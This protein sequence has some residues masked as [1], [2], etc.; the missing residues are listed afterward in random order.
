[1]IALQ[2]RIGWRKTAPFHVQL[3]L[4]NSQ[5]VPSALGETRVEGRAIRVF[6]TDGRLAVGDR[7][8]FSI[9]VC[10]SGGE[11]TGPAYIYVDDLSRANLMEAYLHGTPPEYE[12]AAYEFRIIDTAS[13]QP[14]LTLLAEHNTPLAEEVRTPAKRRRWQ[15]WKPL[16]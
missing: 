3:E 1:M 4:V 6:R 2:G 13:E 7:I 12:L 5:C 8:A 10:E 16:K 9:W 14:Y 15:F 11:P